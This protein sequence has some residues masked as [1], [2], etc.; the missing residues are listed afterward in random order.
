MKSTGLGVLS[1]FVFRSPHV[2]RNALVGSL[3]RVFVKCLA[4]DWCTLWEEKDTHLVGLLDQF[5]VKLQ[6][7]ALQSFQ[8]SDP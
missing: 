3:T 4:S 1:L 7:Q 5:H 8:S 2:R 6:P